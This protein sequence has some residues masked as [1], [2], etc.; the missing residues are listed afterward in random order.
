M[1]DLNKTLDHLSE[2]TD[3]LENS[4]TKAV[5]SLKE[6]AEVWEVS[7]NSITEMETQLNHLVASLREMI[8][9]FRA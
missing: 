7:S 5:T 1:T 8:E 6:L 4:S 3:S 2:L 9:D